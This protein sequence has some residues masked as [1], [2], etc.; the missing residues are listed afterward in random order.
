[1]NIEFKEF[2]EFERGILYKQLLDSYS[3]DKR[4]KEHFEK[5]WIEYDDFFYNN[6]IFTN[7]CGFVMV[8]DGKPIGHISWDPRHLPDYVEIGHNCILTQYKGNGYGHLL[9]EEAIKRIRKYENISKIIV[10]TNEKLIPAQHNYESVGFQLKRKRINHES[11][12]SGE[13]MDYEIIF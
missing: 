9:L 8:L 5:D 11:P 2:R 4:W 12:F 7:H 6:L 1:M 3:F 13:Y 10:T